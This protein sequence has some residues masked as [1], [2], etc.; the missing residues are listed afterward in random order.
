MGVTFD[1]V[2][3][4]DLGLLRAN[5][6]DAAHAGHR[7]I[8]VAD[9]IGGGPAGEVA[10]RAA[11]AAIAEMEAADESDLRAAFTAA[12][13]G[14]RAAA[15]QDP[16]LDGMGTTLTAVLFT[17]PG[18]ALLGHIGDSRA[19]LWRDGMLS[20]LTRDDT[21]VQSLVDEGLI[22]AEQ[23]RHHPQKSLITRSLHGQDFIARF[24]K[25]ITRPNDRYLL[26]TDGLSDMVSDESIAAAV[27]QGRDPRECAERLVRLALQAGGSDNVTV[28]VAFLH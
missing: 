10:S 11:I 28:V 13:L 21:Y 20:R 27:G 1:A 25:L 18:E 7:V 16:S 6:E 2:V 12:D 5:N 17:E 26:C 24:A 23:A 19:Y 22:D 3:L 15:K 14:I 9:G 4:T 8:A